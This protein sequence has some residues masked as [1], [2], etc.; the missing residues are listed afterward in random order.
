MEWQNNLQR[1]VLQEYLDGIED[2]GRIYVGR[3][4][5]HPPAPR[6]ALRPGEAPPGTFDPPP[7]GTPAEPGFRVWKGSETPP[8][9]KAILSPEERER[10]R[11][12]GYIH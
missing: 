2:A 4:Q 9:P 7:P 1:C 11:A 8:P 10:L 6:F 5:L 12:L 3:D